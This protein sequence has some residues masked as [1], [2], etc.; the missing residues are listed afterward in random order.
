MPFPSRVNAETVVATA[1][2]LV[3]AKGWEHWSLRDVAGAVGVTANALYRH[4]GDKAGL[5]VAMGEVATRDMLSYM[6]DGLPNACDND[7]DKPV[8]H[9]ALRFVEFA[10]KQPA[11]YA[12]FIHAKPDP[13][14]PGMR[15][16][17][18]FWERVNALV[19]QSH[20]DAA[21]ATGF[22]LW[23]FLHGRVELANGPAKLAAADAGLEEAVRALLSGFRAR[24]PV[25]SP[26]PP[27]ARRDP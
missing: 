11:R 19:R 12:A 21:D 22:A 7:P 3:E 4:V 1:L 13:T 24:S 9:I 5:V 10:V 14:H 6:F 18:E 23:A 16:W 20:P 15:A 25:E 17:V 8:V 2:E 26:L 27:H